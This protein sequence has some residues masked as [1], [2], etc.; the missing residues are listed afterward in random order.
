MG[1][2]EDP[3]KVQRLVD[4][5]CVDLVRTYVPILCQ[6]TKGLLSRLTFSPVLLAAVSG[7][8]HCG[9]GAPAPHSTCI[10]ALTREEEGRTQESNGGWREDRKRRDVFEDTLQSYASLSDCAKKWI[11]CRRTDCRWLP[12]TSLKS[13]RKPDDKEWKLL[14]NEDIKI[15][16]L[17]G[18]RKVCY[19]MLPFALKANANVIAYRQRLWRMIISPQSL[20]RRS[21]SLHVLGT[22]P[23]WDCVDAALRRL[24]R[25]SSI[26]I[27]VKSALLAGPRKSLKYGLRKISR[28]LFSRRSNWTDFFRPS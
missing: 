26:R 23:P 28:R 14:L 17:D 10:H 19:E 12:T 27:A 2:A 15:E 20:L 16:W 4:S 25:R 18:G 5:Q 24:V 1:V 11:V 9:V 3:D 13:S 6:D 21:R 8:P 22:P 7:Q